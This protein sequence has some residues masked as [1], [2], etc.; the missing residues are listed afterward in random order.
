MSRTAV[1]ATL[2]A[3]LALALIGFSSSP[4]TAQ[5]PPSVLKAG[6]MIGHTNSQSSRIWLQTK[7][8][9]AVSI[10]W[11]ELTSKAHSKADKAAW[12]QVSGSSQATLENTLTLSLTQLKAETRY[13]YQVFVGAERALPSKTLSFK[14]QPKGREATVRIAFG[15]CANSQRFPKQPIFEAIAKEQANAF[16]FLGDAIYFSRKDCKDP[17]RMWA[18][19]LEG[20]SRPKLQGLLH[21][22]PCYGVWDDH[23]YGP[24][25]SDKGF[26][27]RAESLKIF[28]AYW[29][30]A[31]YGSDKTD[32]IWSKMSLGAADVFLLDDRSHR[33]PNRMRDKP[34]KT[35]YGKV[36]KAWL[37]RELQASKAPFKIIATGGQMLAKYHMFEGHQQYRYERRWLIDEIMKRGVTG[38]VF[39][40]GDRHL[41][42]VIRWPAT[43]RHY[44]LYDITSSPLA[45]NAWAR[46]DELATDRRLCFYGKGNSYGLLE[47]SADTMKV[48]LRDEQGKVA[49]KLEIKAS[50]LRLP[51]KG[52]KRIF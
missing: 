26:K 10:K 4:I 36:Q 5:S 34:S 40:S 12:S 2:S 35:Q 16:L 51:A 23:D 20:R 1:V 27:L 17:K 43:D 15:S 48:S 28:K 39:L 9:A 32:G 14:T 41:S 11:R 31:A 25:N 42:E 8:P 6:P 37:L 38:V 47:V 30:N 21:G 46:G 45:N 52:K 24:N 50:D 29:A 49:A 19:W 13:E 44:A 7:A 18:R 22:T 33:D 3:A